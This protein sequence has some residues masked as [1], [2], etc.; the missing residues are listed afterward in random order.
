VITFLRTYENISF[1]AAV[2]RLLG[3]L[4]FDPAQRAA[5]AARYVA[6]Q[7]A[8]GIRAEAL[9][10]RKH[11]KALS[12]VERSKPIAD[13]VVQTYLGVRGIDLDVTGMPCDLGVIPSL[14][15]WTSSAEFDRPYLVGY[16]PAMV[17][18]MR[19]LQGNIQAAHVT[20][21]A[22]DGS[23]KADIIDPVTGEILKSKKIHG[24]PTG[25]AIR[26]YPAD[27][28]VAIGE[29]IESSLSVRQVEPDQAVWC[30][31]SRGNLVG[32]GCARHQSQLNHHYRSKGMRAPETIRP[33]P[34]RPGLLLPPSIGMVLIIADNDGD[35]KTNRP[36]IARG[37]KKFEHHGHQVGVIWPARGLDAN[38]MVRAAS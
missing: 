37:V 32:A 8:A 15:Y 12:L 3:R 7:K 22:K 4:D 9:A 31:A 5:A 11:D 2:S 20:Y 24:S 14:E 13:S 28:C 33:D 19:D 23:G 38:D 29:G 30:A 26:L 6:E 36:L 18:A 21:L 34:E 27:E 16:F 1:T 35:P 17:A 25:C 10:K